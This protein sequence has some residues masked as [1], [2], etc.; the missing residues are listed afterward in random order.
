MARAAL[1]WTLAELAA[2]TKVHVNTVRRCEAGY[3]SLAGTLQKIENV[4]RSEGIAFVDEDEHYGPGIRGPKSATGGLPA[5]AKR[6]PRIA[7]T[8]KPKR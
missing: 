2:R 4:F 8:G 1:G 3:E 7:K 6:R 5:K